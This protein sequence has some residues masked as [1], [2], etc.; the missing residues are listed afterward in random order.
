MRSSATRSA[1]ATVWSPIATSTASGSG[2][3]GR[4]DLADLVA[5]LDRLGNDVDRLRVEAGEIEE[6]LDQGG[7]ALRLLEERFAH[8]LSLARR[9][10]GRNDGAAS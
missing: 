3:D 6:L 7:H 8:Q 4:N 1:T 5:H 10:A 2:D 9:R